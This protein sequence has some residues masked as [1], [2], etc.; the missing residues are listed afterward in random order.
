MTEE[1]T[2]YFIDRLV[3]GGE[4]A[5][6]NCQVGSIGN[7]QHSTYWVSTFSVVRDRPVSRWVNGS[8]CVKARI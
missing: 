1:K 3:L 2:A 8:N 5:K 7:V 4:E 6:R